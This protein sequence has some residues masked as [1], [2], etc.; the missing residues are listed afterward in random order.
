M[1]KSGVPQGG[2]LSPIIFVKY[3]ADMELWLKHSFALTYADDTET[4]VTG[5]TIERVKEKLEEE[6][7]KVLSFMA[8]KRPHKKFTSRLCSKFIPDKNKF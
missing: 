6:A 8:S 2:I 1:L 4:S 5:K 3:G 7:E